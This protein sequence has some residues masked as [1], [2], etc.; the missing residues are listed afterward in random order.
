MILWSLNFAGERVATSGSGQFDCLVELLRKAVD[1]IDKRSVG[2]QIPQPVLRQV[3]YDG[4]VQAI[5]ES[6]TTC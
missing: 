6:L 2:T 5:I 3:C 1:E 4:K